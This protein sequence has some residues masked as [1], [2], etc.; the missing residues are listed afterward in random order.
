MLELLISIFMTL[1]IHYTVLDDR[2][3]QISASDARILSTSGEFQ[4]ISDLLPSETVII[5]DEIDPT[6]E[7]TNAK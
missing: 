7:A 5:A 3:V 4:R 1:N 2:Y 6:S